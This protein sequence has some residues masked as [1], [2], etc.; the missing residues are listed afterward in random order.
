MTALP[1]VADLEH[2]EVAGFFDE[3]CA[4]YDA[5]YD[6]LEGHA[7]R[8]RLACVLAAVGTVP[9]DVLDA[10]MGP[11]RLCRELEGRG[12]RSWGIDI[13]PAMVQRARERVPDAVD[14]L[15]VGELEALPFGANTF[16]AV[17]A[18]GVLEYLDELPVAVQELVRVARPG[19]RIVLTLPNSHSPRELWRR[20]VWYP[21]ARAVKHAFPEA[22][23]RPA[24]YRKPP[25]ASPADLEAL[26]VAVG[27]QVR[28]THR[29]GV[30]VPA[31]GP[32]AVLPGSGQRTLSRLESTP[33]PRAV[34]A[35]QIVVVAELPAA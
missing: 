22:F 33:T 17:V 28:K 4:R 3:E 20:H 35:T 9:G 13:S 24:P 6:A 16:D 5:A 8:A 12:W 15:D 29:V 18:M 23:H 27:A 21:A 30:V 2:A 25:P 34:L 1:A 7:L 32:E 26:L 19:A 10:G 11:G 14:R 31:A